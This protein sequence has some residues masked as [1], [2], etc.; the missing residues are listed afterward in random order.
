[1][2]E[3]ISIQIGQAGTHGYDIRDFSICL[4]YFGIDSRLHTYGILAS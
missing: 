2:P 3:C 4:T 1:M